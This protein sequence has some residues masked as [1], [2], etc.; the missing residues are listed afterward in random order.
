MYYR[1]LNSLGYIFVTDSMGLT[2]NINHCDVIGPKCPDFGEIMQNNG[3][4]AILGA[5]RSPISVPMESPYV[6]SYV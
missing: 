1:K 2:F 3:H 6:T 4:Y 5:S